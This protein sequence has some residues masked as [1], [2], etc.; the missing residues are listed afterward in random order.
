MDKGDLLIKVLTASLSLN[1][2]MFNELKKLNNGISTLNESLSNNNRKPINE[3]HRSSKRDASGNENVQQKLSMFRN[4]LEESMNAEDDTQ[5][6]SGHQFNE[7]EFLGEGSN[8]SSILDYKSKNPD[9][10]VNKILNK[11]NSTNYR[12]IVQSMENK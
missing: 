2:K 1:K 9:D 5:G 10:P 7:A 6:T 4:I 11:I 12:K 3:Q 8:T